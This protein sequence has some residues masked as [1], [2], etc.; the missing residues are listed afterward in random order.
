MTLGPEKKTKG[1]KEKLLIEN[2]KTLGLIGLGMAGALGLL[3]IGLAGLTYYTSCPFMVL[4][5][6]GFTCT[7]TGE[8][9]PKFRF[10]Y[11]RECALFWEK[12]EE[13]LKK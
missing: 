4:E 13:V 5:G 10:L 11:F 9:C 3:L 2:I 7:H 1:D 8:A 6:Q 12:M